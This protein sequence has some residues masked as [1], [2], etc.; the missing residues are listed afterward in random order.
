MKKDLGYELPKGPMLDD[1]KELEQ[2][3]LANSILKQK[4]AATTATDDDEFDF[5]DVSAPTESV[6]AIAEALKRAAVR[7][8][9]EIIE[10][11]PVVDP[12]GDEK[13]ETT[14]VDD[15]VVDDTKFDVRK[16]AKASFSDVLS[17][18]SEGLGDAE[19][20]LLASETPPAS[21]T[22]STNYGAK[23]SATETIEE[24]DEE[25]FERAE[26]EAEQK[27]QELELAKMTEKQMLEAEWEAVN[28]ISSSENEASAAAP[29]R[30]LIDGISLEEAVPHLRCDFENGLLF[31]PSLRSL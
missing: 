17:V 1:E 26:N 19:A 3:L 27:E 22:V 28:E 20:R 30:D 24:C 13:G 8:S 10:S 9:E 18:Y 23:L 2:E 12:Q 29:S 25:E 5:D 21:T 6:S 15:A 4:V 11:G 31:S 7:A 16:A 14:T